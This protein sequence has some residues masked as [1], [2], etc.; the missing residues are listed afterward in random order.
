MPRFQRLHEFLNHIRLLPRVDRPPFRKYLLKHLSVVLLIFLIT[1]VAEHF[2]YFDGQE[3]YAL[4]A[5][6]NLHTPPS[7]AKIVLVEIDD[8]AYESIFD[9]T[10]PLDPQSLHSVLLDLQRG[11]PAVIAVDLVTSSP[12]FAEL[13]WPKAVWVR[14]S[15]V[16]RNSSPKRL[17]QLY[18]SEALESLQPGRF[19]GGK[20]EDLPP[21]HEGLIL[22][23]PASG[24]SLFLSDSD[25]V[26]RRYH[27]LYPIG[28]TEVSSAKTYV[29]SFP[30]AIAKAYAEFLRHKGQETSD[31]CQRIDREEHREPAERAEE[32]VLTIG[33]SLDHFIPLTLQQVREGAQQPY[34][35][36][37]SPLKDAIVIL[38]G[39]YDR[40]HYMTPAGPRHGYQLVAH[41]LE[42]SLAN[43]GIREF[44]HTLAHILDLAVG[45]S[46]LLIL[47]LFPGHRAFL[48]TLLLAGVL[49]LLASFLAF[50]SFAYWFNFAP[51]VGGLWL[52]FQWEKLKESWQQKHE[53]KSLRE[54][55]ARLKQVVSSSETASQHS[56]SPNTSKSH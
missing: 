49:A 41:A 29:E 16:N 43:G 2:G 45:L 1:L 19:L 6:F 21:D 44:N 46:I 33:A 12:K 30:W 13:Q 39:S 8:E 9:G 36:S 31:I 20:I 42:T 50:K 27:Q 56:A 23:K 53:L 40:D 22:T 26:M 24:L 18:S 55:V 35:E 28:H 34:W 37:N 3:T 25:G 7:A 51:M 10:S 32:I 4:D 38:G 17:D 47:W 52:H 11:Q 48:A 54:E 15:E 5:L 14:G